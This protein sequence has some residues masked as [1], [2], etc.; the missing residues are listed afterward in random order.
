MAGRK[1]ET[2]IERIFREVTGRDMNR[3]ERRILLRKP[4]IKRKR[5]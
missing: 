5:H 1:R 3:L 4:R 2:L